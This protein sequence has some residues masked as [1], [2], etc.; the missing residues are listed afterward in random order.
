MQQLFQFINIHECSCY[1]NKFLSPNTKI[2]QNNHGGFYI[3]EQRNQLMPLNWLV[4]FIVSI[5]F[6]MMNPQFSHAQSTTNIYDVRRGDTLTVIAYRHKT[7]IHSL[8]RANGLTSDLIHAGDLLIIPSAPLELPAPL[9]QV[10]PISAN[11][12]DTQILQLPASAK[13][14][15]SNPT[16]QP[17]KSFISR[18]SQDSYV[19]QR[20]DTLHSIAIRSNSSII[21]IKRCNNLHSDSIWAGQVLV[22]IHIPETK[23]SVVRCSQ[24][25]PRC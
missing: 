24:V 3:L 12:T 18:C 6:F 9:Q 14:P 19:V 2:T 22:G 25:D 10:P 13:A 15:Q 20:G 16:P 17:G 8:I 11:P 21:R 7:S 5:T 23:V 1:P 4:I